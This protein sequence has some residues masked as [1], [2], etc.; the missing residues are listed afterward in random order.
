MNTEEN[1][2][3]EQKAPLSLESLPP[4]PERNVAREWEKGQYWSSLLTGDLATV[5]EEVRRK[6][7]AADDALPA[8]EQDYRLAA[9]INRSWVVDHRNMSREEV[10]TAWPDLRHKLSEEL[11]V[12][13]NESEVYAGLSLRHTEEPLRQQVRR[14]FRNN[15]EAALKGE[16]PELPE[17]HEERNVCQVAQSQARQ[18]RDEYMP[19]A[20]SVSQGWSALQAMESQMFFLPELISGTP[21]LLKAVDTLADMEK[22]ER[23][24]VYAIAQSLPATQKRKTAPESL[25]RAMLHGIRRG[26]DDVRY[27]MLQGAGHLVTAFAN[28]TADKLGNQTL[29]AA[30]DAVDKRLQVLH[31]LRGIAHDKVYPIDLG[32]ESSFMEELAVDAA[33]AVPAAILSFMGGAGFGCL[34]LS[35]TGAAVAEARQRSPE[36]RQRLQTVAGLTAA[37]IQAAISVGLSRIGG[38][39]LAK[40]I[41]NF[42]KARN[43]GFKGYS[44]ASLK[45]LGSLSTTAVADLLAGKATRYS[46]LGLQELAARVDRVASNINWEELGES[47]VEVEANLREAAMNLPYYLIGAG[48]AAL[49]HFRAPQALLENKAVL[50]TWGIDE[51]A[52]Q[53]ILELPNIHEQSQALT[54]ALCTSRR[55]GG[56]GML[57]EALR[58]LRL[59]NTETHVVFDG[60]DAVRSFLNLPADQAARKIPEP[61]ERDLSSPEALKEVNL[62]MNGRKTELLNARQLVPLIRIWDEWNHRAMGEWIRVPENFQERAKRYVELDKKHNLALPRKYR[63]DG[64]YTPYRAEVVRRVMND[65]VQELLNLS[66]QYLMNT[67][68]L[69]S[70]RHS[71]KTEKMARDKTEA[72]RQELL[73]HLCVALE[74][75]VRTGDVETALNQFSAFL[76]KKYAERRRLA[77]H[78]PAWMRKAQTRDFENGYMTARSKVLRYDK[79]KPREL[80]EAYRIMLGFRASAQVLLDVIPHTPDFQ[81]LLNMGYSPED[82]FVHLLRR[83]MHG[84]Y[85]TDVWNPAALGPGQKNE[86]DNHRRAL[87]NLKK[88]ERYMRFSGRRLERSPDGAG[89]ELVR[90]ARPDGTYTPWFD[91]TEAV[92]NSLSGRVRS[93]FLPTGRG[94]LLDNIRQSYRYT[95]Q[96]KGFFHAALMYPPQPRL[97]NG[98]DHLGSTASRDIRALWLG[99]STL[100]PLGM[101]FAADKK[102]WQKFVG[103]KLQRTVKRITDGNDGYMVNHRMIETPLSL[104]RIRFLIYWHRL[105]TSG[106]VTPEQVGKT[107]LEAGAIT[108]EGLEAVL[109]PG[110]DKKAHLH[111]MKLEN[112]RKLLRKYPDGIVPGNPAAVNSELARRMAELNVLHLLANLP[113]AKVPDSVREWFY[114]CAFSDATPPENG[115][116]KP[117]YLRRV[118]F[119]SAEEVKRMVP[120]VERFRKLSRNLEL[121]GMMR[122]AYEPSEARRYEQGWCFSVGGASAFRS[123]G[124]S[125]WNLL[126]DPVRGWQLLTP[127]ERRDLH[128]DIR[129]LCRGREPEQALQ[130]LS[131]VLQEYPGLRAYSSDSRHGGQVKRLELEPLR[132]VNIAEPLY[133]LTESSSTMRPIVVKDGFRVD[134]K[135]GLPSEW[136]AD[137][138]VLPALQLLTELRRSVTASP[139][140]D[141]HG[142]WWKQERYGGPDGKRPRGVDEHWSAEV[143]LASFMEFYKRAAAMGDAYGA[144]GLL[145]VCGVPL[146]GIHPGDIDPAVLNNV[147]IYRNPS[148]PEHQVRLMPGEPN[149]S[150]PYQRKPYVVHTADAIPLFSQRMARYEPE[151]I[152]TFKP[153]NT[154]SSDLGR[155]Y[156]FYSNHRWRKRHLEYYLTDLL[157]KRTRTVEDWNMADEGEIN[158]LELFMQVFQDSRL[159]YYLENRNP[160][161]LTRGEALAAELGR[162]MLLA[163][164]GAEQKQHVQ[165]L[166]NFCQKLRRD[167]DD[168]KLL[169]STLNRVVSPDPNRF[170]DIE[171]QVSEDDE[172]I[173]LDPEDV[174]YY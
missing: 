113:T 166:V 128:A 34:A 46:E 157:D 45:T 163:E 60:E 73:G 12:A 17:K 151:I 35:S 5:P 174:E 63:L 55:W 37:G 68:S 103:E 82:S 38:D 90:I 171:M 41:N 53:R 88:V 152:Q 138:R 70:L 81:E 168:Q 94:F 104:S 87:G 95:P 170:P 158:N 74:S 10:R 109:A 107:L 150:N 75:A 85:G 27:Y 83:E 134:E 24:K 160:E 131:D 36:V 42:A 124:Q 52:R 32:P 146:G 4:L 61:P 129:E 58:A 154:F 126:D 56:A 136:L 8:S 165:Q 116:R 71:Y 62:L 44:L 21:G 122:D 11:E 106:W 30:A 164:F 153:L 31:E 93:L 79:K 141:E 76:E 115:H 112:R 130:E 145:N 148:M 66:Y 97:F 105:L 169:R 102:K 25:G 78:A 18:A 118:N 14:L 147:T 92:V 50:E 89:G 77:T 59:L 125:Y 91:S 121:N 57:Q 143:G 137:E 167:R 96:G 149:A 16:T 108:P 13:D 9:S 172:E 19:L 98:F 65:H 39:M 135:A 51:A 99:D 47:E 156:D 48:R 29:S 117:G 80:W 123:S 119:E 49:H 72:K 64:Y 101:E 69:D 140:A 162:L 120:R 7:G 132:T 43:A 142:I 67:E 23:Y 127:E 84:H 3:I 111:H 1:T 26:S 33:E 139:Y 20:E 155:A 86:F 159:S 114:T 100:Y 40:T 133:T 173:N 161:T 110:R 144:N 6:A 54:H 28:A 2:K 22:E 15:Y